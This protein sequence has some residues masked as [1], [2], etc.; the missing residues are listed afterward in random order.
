LLL[1]FAAG[2]L[3]L[4]LQ[5]ERDV[6]IVLT[7]VPRSAKPEPAG[8]GLPDPSHRGDFDGARIVVLSPAGD[9]RVLSEGF[10][11]ACDPDLAFDGR[12]VLFAG[13]KDAGTGWRLWEIGVDGQ[14]LRPVSPPGLE[15]RSPI[16]VSTLFT[17]DSPE[18][19]YT[20]VFVGREQGASETG[21]SSFTSLYNI[22]LDG[23]ELRRLTFNP[24]ANYDPMQMWDGRVIYAAEHH[25]NAP[26]GRAT[27]V[28]LHAIHIE[29]A[30][31]E[32]YGGDQGR[33]IQHMP[34][35]AEGGLVVF[36]EAD[37]I[38]PDGAGQLASVLEQRPTVSY[39]RLTDDPAQR[40][41]YPAPWRDHRL[42]VSRRPA[43]GRG[44]AGLCAIDTRTG[45]CE[46]LFD[47]PEYHELQAKALRPRP[48][49]DGHSTVVN[50]KFETGTFYGLNCYDADARL[51]PHLRT[52]TVKRVRVIEGVVQ[53]AVT[54]PRAGVR[55]PFV[56]RRLIGEAPVEA[57]GSFNVEVPADTPLLLQT[58][59]EQGLAL[60]TCGWIW[61]K[62]K[63]SRGCI[64]CHE[65]PERTPENQY[66]LALRR[67]SNR[68]VLP[69]AQRRTV[70]FRED[71]APLLQ[72]HC[73]A[74]DCHGGKDNSLR[75]SLS[76]QPPTSAEL[77]KTYAALMAPLTDR[78]EPAGAWPAAG[79]YVDAGRAR[80]S[81][82]VW[83]LTGTDTSRPWDQDG[84]PTR[85]GARQ[86]KPMPPP[87]KG[88]PLSTDELRTI[89]QWIDLGAPYEVAR[90]SA[91]PAPVPAR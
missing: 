74:A 13:R 23:G 21:R 17:L 62:P 41:L 34:C 39:Q 87:G 2:C 24:N 6:P 32:F 81:W 11:A 83:Q 52:G 31:M 78:R 36:V 70:T 59:D 1:G 57:D 72:R 8:A 33:R 86:V 7:Q 37:E 49:P 9:L 18:P 89:I 43:R 69:P 55:E 84:R 54:A 79:R 50:P 45:R 12:R 61:V 77:E 63:E 65:D 4:R 75:L 58:L 25:P 66:V 47:S 80:T 67:V 51:Q 3:L 90:V 26:D 22:R 91:N 14:G 29:G 38:S 71:I 16:Y 53:P 40:F 85:G 68:L 28:G 15:A 56:A 60:A 10:Q 42:L 35:A 27:R 5:G 64:G 48:R 46:P 88:T 19:W 20:A 76:A 44:T 82:L 73:A 30:D